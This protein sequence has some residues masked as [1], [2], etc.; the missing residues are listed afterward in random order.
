[1]NKQITFLTLLLIVTVFSANATVWTVSNNPADSTAAQFSDLQA[2]IDNANIDDTILVSG[3]PNQYSG[4]FYIKKKLTLIG[5][6]YNNPYG[7]NTNIRSIYLQKLNASIGAD[8][9]VI[10]GVELY[11]HLDPD[12]LNADNTTRKLEDITISD[13]KINSL[14]FSYNPNSNE[15]HYNNIFIKNNHFISYLNFGQYYTYLSNVIIS[16]NLFDNTGLEVGGNS[17]DLSEVYIENNII[18]N[19]SNNFLFDNS[20]EY[21][22]GEFVKLNLE[23][24][25]FYS[26]KI[27]VENCDECA[28][29]NN[30]TYLSVDNDTL[31]KGTNIGS[32]NIYAQDP[33]FVNYPLG[34]ATWSYSYDL[35]LQSTSPAINAGTD[36]TNMGVYGGDYPWSNIGDNPEIPQM[37][38]ITFP[39]NES[40][41]PLNGTLNVSFKSTKQD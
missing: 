37:M 5:A 7:N 25:I 39:S 16:N 17:L 26:S 6:G 38:E 9:V 4:T 13:C 1:M 12:F 29:N 28:F 30:I 15:N 27:G 31:V 20:N 3:S 19:N 8:G 40:S 18:I 10:K 11:I 24:N 22:T 35:R 23:N 21:S 33:K 34:G 32:G 36:G 41:V 14:Y 2:A